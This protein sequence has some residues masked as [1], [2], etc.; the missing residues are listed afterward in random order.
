MR[1]ASFT[2]VAGYTKNLQ[3]VEA[4]TKFDDLLII[5]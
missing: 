5:F 4:T 1:H 3:L 2:I